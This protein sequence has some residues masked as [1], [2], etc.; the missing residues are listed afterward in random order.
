MFLHAVGDDN[1][2]MQTLE[3]A[4]QLGPEHQYDIDVRRLQA[5]ILRALG[6]ND[7]AITVEQRAE[8][9][10]AEQW[11]LIEQAAQVSQAPVK[12]TKWD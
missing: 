7:E 2:A 4:L 1:K 8:Q 12:R 11:A 3:H 9:F 10:A 5:Q 6:R